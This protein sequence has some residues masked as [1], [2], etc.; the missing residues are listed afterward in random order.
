MVGDD[1]LVVDL[2]FSLLSKVFRFIAK[3]QLRFYVA[4]KVDSGE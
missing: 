3:L 2:A 4:D 1:N